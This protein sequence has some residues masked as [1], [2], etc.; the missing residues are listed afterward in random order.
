MEKN[1]SGLLLPGRSAILGDQSF[2]FGHLLMVCPS[3]VFVRNLCRLFVLC[4]FRILLWLRKKINSAVASAFNHIIIS[5]FLGTK[6]V[7]LILKE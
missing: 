5:F 6:Q 1:W 3:L 7:L 2:D 4:H